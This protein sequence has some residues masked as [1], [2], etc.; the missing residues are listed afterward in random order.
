MATLNVNYGEILITLPIEDS[1]LAWEKLQ[2]PAEWLKYVIAFG[3]KV[4]CVQGYESPEIGNVYK[5]D[6][7]KNYK[8]D[9]DVLRYTPVCGV[10]RLFTLPSSRYCA[11]F[12]LE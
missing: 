8:K 12:S 11:M 2:K 6:Y 10:A 4:E 7:V 9:C 1:K 5:T 3:R